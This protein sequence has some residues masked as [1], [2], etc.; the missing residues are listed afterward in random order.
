MRKQQKEECKEENINR[1]MRHAETANITTPRER[2]GV[3]NKTYYLKS[4]H[5]KKLTLL[6]FGCFMARCVVFCMFYGSVGGFWTLYD[7]MG[8]F[9]DVVW[10]DGSPPRAGER[11][12][13]GLDFRNPGVP[14]R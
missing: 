4:V 2:R 3:P 8:R 1:E 9:L 7:P 5:R 11:P 13:G 12:P 6:L 14:E 10:S